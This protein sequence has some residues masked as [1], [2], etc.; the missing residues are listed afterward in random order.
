MYYRPVQE[1]I[2]ISHPEARQTGFRAGH[3]TETGLLTVRKST[4]LQ[5]QLLSLLF[6]FSFMS[7]QRLPQLSTSSCFCP[8]LPWGFAAQLSRVLSPSSSVAPSWLYVGTAVPRPQK[9]RTRCPPWLNPCPSPLYIKS[10]CSVISSKGP[11]Y[12]SYTDDTQLLLSNTLASA[13]MSAYQQDIS[14]WMANHCLLINLG[15]T[16]Q[17]ETLL[18]YQV[19]P[20]SP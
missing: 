18:P 15:K 7:R 17:V 5:R 10:P 12:N 16:S 13:C 4:T 3:S 20:T 9:C 1:T 8:K 11:S 2:H 6:S 19:Q 14:S